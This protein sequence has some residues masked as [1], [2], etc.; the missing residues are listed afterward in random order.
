MSPFASGSAGLHTITLVA[1][2]P[3]KAW[4]S[5]VSST[6]PPRQRPMAPSP[7]QTSTRGTAQ[8]AA[9]SCHQPAN[10][11]AADRVGINTPDNQRE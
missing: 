11:S 7:S 3:R 1:S 9:I 5:A 6:L 10:T 8:S 4:H 2:V